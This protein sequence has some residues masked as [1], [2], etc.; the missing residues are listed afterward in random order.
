MP[1]D[2]DSQSTMFM[3][4]GLQ[5]LDAA[6]D[7]WVD[8]PYEGTHFMKVGAAGAT[9]QA[10]TTFEL[11]PAGSEGDND[12]RGLVEYQWR[13]GSHLLFSASR[14]TTAGHDAEAGAEPPGFSA[15]TCSIG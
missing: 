6:T 7:G 3:R 11:E 15:A 9:R 10:G 12:L 1:G 5:A 13:V 14:L 4:F 8:V 2:A